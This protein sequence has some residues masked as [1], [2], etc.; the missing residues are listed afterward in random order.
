MLPLLE[1]GAG[2]HLELTGRE[3]IALLASILGLTAAVAVRETP[4]SRPS[5]ESS[6]TSTRRSSATTGMQARLSFA[7]A[8]C[9]PADIYILDE[10]LA[11]VDDDFRDRCDS[12][13]PS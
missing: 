8:I 10:V 2:F 6:A 11:V 1:V 4:G 9:F 7:T 3:N 12:S 5:R 13:S